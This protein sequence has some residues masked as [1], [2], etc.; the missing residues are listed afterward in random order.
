MPMTLSSSSLASF[1]G[2]PVHALCCEPQ[3]RSSNSAEQ[4]AELLYL[5]IAKS[6]HEIGHLNVSREMLGLFLKLF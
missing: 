2:I 1:L 5:R 6:E 4:F 3:V